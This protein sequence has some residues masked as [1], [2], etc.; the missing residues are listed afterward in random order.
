ME[1]ALEFLVM[2]L[3]GWVSRG[4]GEVGLRLVPGPPKSSGL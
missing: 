4:W 2:G 3:V 1:S